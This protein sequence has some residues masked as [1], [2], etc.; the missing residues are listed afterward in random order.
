MTAL[1]LPSQRA[2]FDVPDDV[3][4]F[5]AA[6]NSPL[7]NASRDRLLAGAA[8]KSHPWERTA[9]SFFDDA[10]TV[11]RLA[12]DVLGG[13]ADGY[14]VV[15]AASYGCSAAARA[16]EPTL[17]RGD[18][19]VVMDE[20]FPSNYLPWERSARERGAE[21]VTVPTPA[22][23]DW[24]KAYL[25]LIVPG[26]KVVAAGQC[27]W[28]NGAFV[29]LVVLGEACRAVGASLALDLT[30]SL[31]AMPFDIAAVQPDFVYAAGYKWLLCPYGFGLM[32]V[33]PAWRDARPLEESWLKRENAEN[34]AGLVKYAPKYAPGARRFDVGET[35]V[36]TVLP[37]AIAALEQLKAW[38]VPAIAASLARINA[39]IAEALERFGFALP[40]QQLRSPH[41]FGA[42]LPARYRGNLVADLAARRIYISQRGNAVRFAPHLHV[43]AADLDRLEQSLEALLR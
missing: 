42:Q 26:V 14:A 24:T 43:N 29:D 34:F 9:A 8:S 20:E 7:L 15:P 27:H 17:G 37:G 28:T 41:M 35:V 40:P 19:I 2:L 38:S 5:N 13:D 32:Y 31:G 16:V 6:Y 21:I 3:A 1:E 22:D 33:A 23:G 36:P 11:R 12:S 39:R 18:K 10:D 30:Q 25:T 4:Y